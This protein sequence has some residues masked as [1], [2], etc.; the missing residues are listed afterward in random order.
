MVGRG[1]PHGGRAGGRW[2]GRGG[3]QQADL[4]PA[5]D[6]KA[7][8]AGR[9]PDGWF[10]GDVEVTVDR[11][12]IHVM[13]EL[14]ALRDEFAD[15]A[16][17][18]AAEAGRI[19]RFR[20]DSRDE[21]IEIARQAEHR[22]GRKVAWGAR[23]G[24][25]QEMFTTLSVPVMTRLRQPERLV[26][27]TLVDAGVARS[28]SEALAWAVRLVGGHAQQWLGELQQAMATVDDLRARGPEL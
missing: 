17:R 16:E 2:H 13:G 6:A 8:F 4:P 25:T 28:R 20:E 26:L 18:A 9:L 5:D 23:L 3:W 19:S 12:E 7:W 14:P 11:E 10:T 27:D 21:R 1:R 24:G 22:Y 15:D